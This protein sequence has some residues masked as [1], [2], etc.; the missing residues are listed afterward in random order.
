M[1]SI[2]DWSVTPFARG[3]NQTKIS[4]EIDA[5]NQVAQQ[6]CEKLSIPF[7]DVTPLSRTART[8]ASLIANDELHFSGKMYRQWAEKA[9]P[10][11]Q[12]LLR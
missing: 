12:R 2:P 10:T 6:E 4:S 7:I 8:D 9:L 11:V 1:L 3:S 5:F